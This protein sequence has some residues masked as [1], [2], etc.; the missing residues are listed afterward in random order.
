MTENREGSQ[1]NELESKFDQS[2]FI[3][4]IPGQLP[5]KKIVTPKFSS[6]AAKDHKGHFR[7]ILTQIF[8]FGYFSWY[9]AYSFEKNKLDFLMQNLILNRLA[10]IS[11]L[12]NEEA[13]SSH[14]PF[15]CSF[16]IS[17]LFN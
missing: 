4:T 8:K 7:K 13:K 15:N 16:S 5:V 3:H 14:A 9:H 17:D 2:Y 12:K 1:V 11:N 6:F 10:P